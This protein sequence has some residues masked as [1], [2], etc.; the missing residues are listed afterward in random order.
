MS[1]LGG[2][3]LLILWMVMDLIDI[4]NEAHKI[5]ESAELKKET[6]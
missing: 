5:R 4:R 6:K 2:I 3:N 1:K